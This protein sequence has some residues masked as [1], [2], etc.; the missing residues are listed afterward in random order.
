M[1]DCETTTKLP[2]MTLIITRH[3]LFILCTISV[4]NVTVFSVVSGTFVFACSCVNWIF[5]LRWNCPLLA[6][7]GG[8]HCAL[9]NI[10]DQYYKYSSECNGHFLTRTFV[11]WLQLVIR[12]MILQNV[13]TVPD[14]SHGITHWTSFFLRL[15]INS[16]GNVVCFRSAVQESIST[17]WTMI[18][19]CCMM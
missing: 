4:K 13:V 8:F 14:T 9:L 17:V 15:L 7:S 10:A 16:S 11:N 1:I 12:S 2:L 6:V 3:L 19:H 5:L 18:K